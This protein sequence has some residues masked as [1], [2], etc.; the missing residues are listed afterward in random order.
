MIRRGHVILAA[1]TASGIVLAVACTF[2]DI[3][4]VGESS[5]TTGSGAGSSSTAGS[6]GSGGQGAATSSTGASSSTSASTSS[7]T[8]M[9]TGGAPPCIKPCDCDGDGFKSAAADC[10]H[11]GGDCND[12]DPAVYPGQTMFFKTPSSTGWDYNCDSVDEFEV[13]TVLVCP[14]GALGCDNTTLG[15]H[16]SVPACG[17]SGM[18]GTCQGTTVT[19]CSEKLNGG[20]IQRCH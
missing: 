15:W 6:G 18:S 2:P 9:G 13:T 1:T 12:H 20:Q 14:N 5:A 3:A 19:G 17:Q 16:A 10:N 4:F 8:G 7:S 11:D